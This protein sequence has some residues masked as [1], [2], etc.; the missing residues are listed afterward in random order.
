MLAIDRRIFDIPLEERLQARTSGFDKL[1]QD[2]VFQT[3]RSALVR[4]RTNQPATSIIRT[5]SLTR[6]SLSE[7]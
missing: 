2:N 6:Q 3:I 4:F 5:I 7:T 1:D